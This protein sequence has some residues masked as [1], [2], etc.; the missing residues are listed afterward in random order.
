MKLP[1]LFGELNM[2][3]AIDEIKLDAYL[4][5][6]AIF[7]LSLNNLKNKREVK[8]MPQKMVRKS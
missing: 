4:K 1:C 5:S 2:Q 3:N 7:L 8:K 6:L